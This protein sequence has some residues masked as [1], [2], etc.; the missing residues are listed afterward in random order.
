MNRFVRSDPIGIINDICKCLDVNLKYIRNIGIWDL[1]YQVVLNNGLEIDI[2]QHDD[3]NTCIDKIA[4]AVKNDTKQGKSILSDE[5]IEE[6]KEMKKSI[7][8]GKRKL[9]L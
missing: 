3:I 2:D 8:L 7:S 5:E 1:P 9:D 6:R 4:S